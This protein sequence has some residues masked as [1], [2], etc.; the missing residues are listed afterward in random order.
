[1]TPE[2]TPFARVI[3]V[4]LVLG[5]VRCDVGKDHRRGG[6]APPVVDGADLLQGSPAA[7]YSALRKLLLRDPAKLRLVARCWVACVDGT[8][9]PSADTLPIASQLA[10][11]CRPLSR[12]VISQLPSTKL[13]RL[14]HACL[15]LRNVL[16]EAVQ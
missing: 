8:L 2:F 10:D 15:A 14:A 12:N 4:S 6:H 11:L 5:A 7:P 13:Q 9:L 1:M 16:A 3:W